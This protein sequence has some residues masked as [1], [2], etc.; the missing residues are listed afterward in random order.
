MDRALSQ[1]I[2]QYVGVAAD[3]FP[4]VA[5]HVGADLPIS[6]EDWAC[7]DVDQRGETADGVKYFKHGYGV[8]MTDGSRHIDLDL[9][10]EGQ[11]DGFD[12]WRLFDFAEK[13]DIEIPFGSHECLDGV[14]ETAAGA[15]ELHFSGYILYYRAHGI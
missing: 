11:I 6:N 3:L 15:G 5:A 1:L 14:L 13:N 10:D 9:G 7:L 8:A 4:K 12:A 2:S